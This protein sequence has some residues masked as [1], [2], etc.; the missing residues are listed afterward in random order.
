MPPPVLPG[1]RGRMTTSPGTSAVSAAFS[2]RCA[3]GRR[4]GARRRYP[5]SRA[6]AISRRSHRLQVRA[7][8]R[9]LWA[10]GT[11]CDDAGEHAHSSPSAIMRTAVGGSLLDPA[12]DRRE[13]VHQEVRLRWRLSSSA[14]GSPIM[15]ARSLAVMASRHSGRWPSSRQ[16]SKRRRRNGTRSGIPAGQD[17]NTSATTVP[18]ARHRP[19]ACQRAPPTPP[20]TRAPRRLDTGFSPTTA[21]TNRAAVT[22]RQPR[23]RWLAP[24]MEKRDERGG[25]HAHGPG[26]RG[27]VHSRTMCGGQTGG[28]DQRPPRLGSEQALRHAARR[29][30]QRGAVARHHHESRAQ[31][32]AEQMPLRL[33]SANHAALAADHQLVGGSHA[34]APVGIGRREPQ[35]ERRGAERERVR[36]GRRER[37]GHVMDALDGAGSFGGGARPYRSAAADEHAVPVQLVRSERGDVDAERCP[38]CLQRH[39]GANPLHAARGRHGGE[40]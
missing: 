2:T 24:R 36:A 21:L 3:R 12:A 32:H 20:R 19:R 5:R 40:P 11:R 16:N 17:R 33:I 39:V 1:R 4:A 37:V 22:P 28:A 6:V 34:E 14:S 25:Q 38:W 29:E 23:G 35:M 30:R 18:R 7:T 26:E 8:G 13:R 9:Q 31:Q 15:R 27:M 10:S